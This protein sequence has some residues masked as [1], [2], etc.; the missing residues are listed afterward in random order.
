MTKSS[1]SRKKQQ[2]IAFFESFRPARAD[3]NRRM[4]AM[5]RRKNTA[6]HALKQRLGG[7]VTESSFE[8]V[9]QTI[10][11][12]A[13]RFRY[14]Y[15]RIHLMHPQAHDDQPYLRLKWNQK[16]TKS[17]L[18]YTTTGQSAV[19][20]AL[21]CARDMYGRR[22]VL[23][24]S[25]I[26]YETYDFLRT[27]DFAI[28][29][30]NRRNDQRKA[31]IALIDSSTA[32]HRSPELGEHACAAIIDTTCWSLGSP[33]VQH[34]VDFF[35]DRNIDVFLVRSHIKIDCLGTEWNR[36][37][38]LL[39]LSRNT[40]VDRVRQLRDQYNLH[41][42]FF[43]VRAE[44]PAVYPFL[45]SRRF[46]RLNEA[47]IERLQRCNALVFDELSSG[48]PRADV[49]VRGF[50]HRLF[51]W[52]ILKNCDAKTNRERGQL[53]VKQLNQHGVAA[54][55]IASYPWDFL[56]VTAFMAKHPFSRRRGEFP[57]IRLSVPDCDDDVLAMA[58][59]VIR[60][61]LDEL[62]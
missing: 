19:S 8:P 38:S 2:E 3:T 9:Q 32:D 40:E 39:F 13:F 26:Y 1:W 61:W 53:L 11:V 15:Q 6:A 31:T 10:R 35:L 29:R 55:F 50:H 49:E 51:T 27:Y 60:R 56:S 41:G 33:I 54:C 52:I 23:M 14:A 46:H 62:C 20:V 42:N 21:F 47:W 59:R 28:L 30:S 45:K 24:R 44:I 36:L 25:D 34:H 16:T 5:S 57:V 37:G 17:F 22:P 43:G 7:H 18:S 58:R 4:P 12:G 48:P